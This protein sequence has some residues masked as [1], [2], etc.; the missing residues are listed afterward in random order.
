L[1][2]AGDSTIGIGELARAGS[3]ALSCCAD[4]PASDEVADAP[5]SS[6]EGF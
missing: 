4:I 5:G 3:G 6:D 1:S 2:I